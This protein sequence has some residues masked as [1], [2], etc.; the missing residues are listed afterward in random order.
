MIRV[1]G[2]TGMDVMHFGGSSLS[3]VVCSTFI[4]GVYFTVMVCLTNVFFYQL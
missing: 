1:F 3:C 2:D 4:I